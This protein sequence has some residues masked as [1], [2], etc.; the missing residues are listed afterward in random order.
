MAYDVGLGFSSSVPRAS[1][2]KMVGAGCPVNLLLNG[3]VLG[4]VCW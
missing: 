3:D 4:M 1:E 2:G